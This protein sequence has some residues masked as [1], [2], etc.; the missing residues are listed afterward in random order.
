MMIK[1]YNWI[2]KKLFWFFIGGVAFAGGMD[3]LI[4]TE[5]EV[6]DIIDIRQER[7]LLETGKYCQFLKDRVNTDLFET[8]I[9]EHDYEI[10]V[11]VWEGGK[12]DLHNKRGYSVRLIPEPIPFINSTST[13]Q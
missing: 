9:K 12:G 6:R 5:A 13:Q 3:V 7:C 11:D 1:I 2:K 4:Q 10:V 8:K